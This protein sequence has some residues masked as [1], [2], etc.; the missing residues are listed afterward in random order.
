MDAIVE[1]LIYRAPSGQWSG[2][3]LE[4]TVEIAGIAGCS[5]PAEVEAEARKQWPIENVFVE[6]T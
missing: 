4:N 2:R 6:D 3:L 1:L 5:S